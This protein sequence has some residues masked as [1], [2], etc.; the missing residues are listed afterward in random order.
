MPRKLLW[1]ATVVC[2][3]VFSPNLNAQTN[4]VLSLRLMED[5]AGTVLG[6]PCTVVEQSEVTQ[7]LADGTTLTQHTIVHKW[8]DD[9]GRFRRESAGVKG[10]EAP[11]FQHASIIDPVNKTFV[12]LNLDRKTATVYHLP[13]SGPDALHPYVDQFD[14]EILALPGVQ[15]KVEKLGG[16]TIAG[17][18]AEGRRVT[19][20]RPPGTV[21]NDKPLVSVR[22][23]WVA[24]DLKILL[25]SSLDDPRHKQ[26]DQ[27]T[28]LER[29]EPDPGLFT[30]P[31]D[32]TVKDVT[33]PASQNGQ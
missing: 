26:V 15:V 23:Q 2:A 4:P 22:D 9:Q 7:Q 32:F 10:D 8:R 21:G 6:Q 29:S 20:I 1:W 27:V 3:V 28:Q 24:Q 19:R 17:V 14:K 18:Y 31:S 30:I 5:D 12:N 11:V 25:A 13:D 33:V 16:K